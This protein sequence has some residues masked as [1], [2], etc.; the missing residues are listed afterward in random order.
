M[1]ENSTTEVHVYVCICV[2]MHVYV[3][4]ETWLLLEGFKSEFFS[5][6]VGEI[7]HPN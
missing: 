5:F 7:G 4:R 1:L 3:E 2:H 6:K